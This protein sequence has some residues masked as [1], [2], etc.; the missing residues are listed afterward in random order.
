MTAKRR[1][2][3]RVPTVGRCLG[4][5]RIALRDQRVPTGRDG[6]SRSAQGPELVPAA[7][8]G[9]GS[10]GLCVNGYATDLNLCQNA[11]LM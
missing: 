10:V 2:L 11:A 3:V 9:C 6:K 5:D 1:F 7:K 4:D 8:L